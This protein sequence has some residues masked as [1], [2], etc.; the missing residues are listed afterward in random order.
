MVEQEELNAAA[1]AEKEA[2][3]DRLA[4]AAELESKMA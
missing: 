2:N 1:A 3:A 4:N